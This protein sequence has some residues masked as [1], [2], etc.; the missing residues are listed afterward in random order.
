MIL[1]VGEEAH[2]RPE[3]PKRSWVGKKLV[4]RKGVWKPL[5]AT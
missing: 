3:P 1:A 4:K 2:V 5:A